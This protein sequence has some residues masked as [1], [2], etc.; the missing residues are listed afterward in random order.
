[1]IPPHTGLQ[2]SQLHLRLQPR[3][4]TPCHYRNSMCL[5]D[6]SFGACERL[7]S[8]VD[9]IE[10]C[11]RAFKSRN[12]HGNVKVT[13]LHFLWCSHPQSPWCFF[14]RPPLAR[15]PSAK[16]AVQLTL[17]P[18]GLTQMNVNPTT[19]SKSSALSFAVESFRNSRWR[20]LASALPIPKAC[21]LESRQ[22]CH[23]RPVAEEPKLLHLI[24]DPFGLHSH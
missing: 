20:N 13:Y 3:S 11:Q 12:A 16:N 21:R 22:P 7:T 10:E 18:Q 24:G 9:N 4:C 6:R 8:T 15:V 23:R 5:H 1:L 17:V 14:S 19:S 2:V